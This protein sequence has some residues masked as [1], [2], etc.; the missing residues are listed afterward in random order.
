V[1]RIAIRRL[2]VPFSCYRVAH[3]EAHIRAEV[4]ERIIEPVH[5]GCKHRGAVLGGVEH[6][7]GLDG[8][9][10]KAP[11]RNAPFT[12]RQGCWAV[13][14]TIRHDKDSQVCQHAGRRIR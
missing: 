5:L 7:D 2:K 4:Q 10:V 12:A 14:G 3:V 1:A 13:H 6:D 11:V 8:L 9:S